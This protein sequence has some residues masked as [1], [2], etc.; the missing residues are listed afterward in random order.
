VV[1]TKLRTRIDFELGLQYYSQQAFAQAIACFER[2]L[3]VQSN[4]TAAQLYLQ[5]ARHWQTYGVS[6]DWE[7]TEVYTEK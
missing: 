4:D 5:R 7:A 1:Q 3:H 2:V 6:I